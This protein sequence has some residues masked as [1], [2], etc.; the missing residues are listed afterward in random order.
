MLPARDEVYGREPLVCLFVSGIAKKEIRGR[1]GY[2]PLR[3][4]EETD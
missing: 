2:F 4:D 3:I 1:T